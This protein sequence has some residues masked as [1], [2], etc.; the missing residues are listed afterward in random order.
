MSDLLESLKRYKVQ[1]RDRHSDPSNT[2]KH[3]IENEL[4]PIQL[5]DKNT[6]DLSSIIIEIWGFKD[7]HLA[8]EFKIDNYSLVNTSFK[9]VVAAAKNNT[10]L[11]DTPSA[12]RRLFPIYFITVGEG[13]EQELIYIG[14]TLSGERF[15]NGHIVTQK[16]NNPIYNGKLKR[17]H[18]AQL[19]VEFSNDGEELL[20]PV[21]WIC[22][23]A[24]VTDIVLFLERT[25]MIHF[26][27]IGENL[28]NIAGI[29]HNPVMALT[30]GAS[31]IPLTDRNDERDYESVS[32]LDM[33]DSGFKMDLHQIKDEDI[34]EILTEWVSKLKK[35]K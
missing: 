2:I 6:F 29:T 18:F 1:N 30:W 19:W 24:L 31:G 16:L 32:I 33:C 5:P 9:S 27:K 35:N 15:T 12:K 25:L 34:E 14:Q 13:D 23:E 8:H 28:F 11:Y 21:E 22:N 17:V 3:C 26:K 7:A 4:V 10:N 20:C